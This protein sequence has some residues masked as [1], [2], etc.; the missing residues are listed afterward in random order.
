MG[1]VLGAYKRAIKG[2][3]P[4]DPSLRWDDSSRD[5]HGKLNLSIHHDSCSNRMIFV[6][7]KNHS[8]TPNARNDRGKD[9]ISLIRIFAVHESF[10]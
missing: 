8:I 4:L 9:Y 10:S 3:G 6:K 2:M 1:E 5:C 7:L